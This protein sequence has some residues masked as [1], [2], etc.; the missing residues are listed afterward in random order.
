MMREIVLP[1]YHWIREAPASPQT[2]GSTM[3]KSPKASKKVT[4]TIPAVN[5]AWATLVSKTQKLDVDATTAVITFANLVTSRK[6]DLRNA[7][8]SVEELGTKSPILLTSQ[9]EALP[10][11][12]ELLAKNKGFEAFHS[13][14]IKEKLTK[15][16]AAYKLGVGIASQMPTWE[17]VAKEVKEFN[18][19]KNKKASTSKTD[20]EAKTPKAKA[21][22][23]ELLEQAI[24]FI[25]SL[26]IA[27]DIGDLL[28]E[29]EATVASKIDQFN[30]ALV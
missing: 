14:T 30:E 11:L 6:I 28:A 20:K 7:R 3:S 17:A 23:A 1:W 13:L 8:K 2:K 29:L 19:R 10:T 27:E 24:M 25:A 9:I 4:I 16:T 12:L 26:P 22:D 21:T 18:A 15:A 5:T